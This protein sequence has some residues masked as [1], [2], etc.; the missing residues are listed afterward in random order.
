[1]H[2]LGADGTDLPFPPDGGLMPSQTVT[3]PGALVRLATWSIDRRR[4]VVGL[5]LALPSASGCSVASPAASTTSSSGPRERSPTTRSA[6]SRSTS[7]RDRA[8]PSTWCSGP[9]PAPLIPRSGPRSRRCWPTWPCC[10]TSPG[11]SRRMTLHSGTRSRRSIRPSRTR[12]SSS[13][14]P[15]RISRTPSPTRWWRPPRRPRHR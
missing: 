14:A 3:R 1:M 15:A 9:A 7:R 8:T 6:C 2:E 13:T 11:C 4:T 12:A 5:W 10:R